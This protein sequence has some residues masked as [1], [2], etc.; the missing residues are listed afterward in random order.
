MPEL[1]L[2]SANLALIVHDFDPG[3]IEKVL[4]RVR[5]GEKREYCSR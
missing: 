1:C 2:S 3:H 5:L 4:K